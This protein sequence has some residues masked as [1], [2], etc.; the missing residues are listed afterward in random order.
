MCLC[1]LFVP[2]RGALVA[3][4]HVQQ[5]PHQERPLLHPPEAEEILRGEQAGLNDV[6]Q[7]RSAALVG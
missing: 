5:R 4:Q 1:R 6:P 7:D 3:A 2:P